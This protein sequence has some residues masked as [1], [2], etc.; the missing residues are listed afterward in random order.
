MTRRTDRSHDVGAS[1][2]AGRHVLGL[3]GE[4][5][6]YLYAASAKRSLQSLPAGRRRRQDVRQGTSRQNLSIL[7]EPY[8]HL[9]KDRR[10]AP[11]AHDGD[12]TGMRPAS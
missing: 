6:R 8:G 2:L 3:V 5:I 4:I 1:F 9:G 7:D 10:L 12:C 11:N